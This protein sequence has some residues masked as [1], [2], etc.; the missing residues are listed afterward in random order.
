LQP[1]AIINPVGMVANLSFRFLGSP[2]ANVIDPW[3]NH[4][5]AS[6]P[7][8]RDRISGLNTACSTPDPGVMEGVETD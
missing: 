3:Q 5:A 2:E 6:R 7:G 4:V 1:S 8:G